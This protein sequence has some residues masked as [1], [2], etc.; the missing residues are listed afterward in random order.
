MATYASV[1][2]DSNYLE[3]IMNSNPSPNNFDTNN[4]ISMKLIDSG[5]KNNRDIKNFELLD[6]E[7]L[8]TNLKNNYKAATLEKDEYKEIELDENGC[9]SYLHPSK[10]TH[11]C[12]SQNK[13][14][15][16]NEKCDDWE[17]D[18]DKIIKE[19]NE[20]L[21]IIKMQTQLNEMRSNLKIL[22]SN[23]N[24]E[25]DFSEYGLFEIL[26]LVGISLSLLIFLVR[27]HR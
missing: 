6:S 9:Q 15:K 11:W 20:K 2:A 23:E 22:D 17:T 10:S 26:L 24:N 16:L 12:E 3:N 19:E 21:D 13:C 1:T 8:T 14:L 7:L 18:I 27:N 25:A 4:D 5:M